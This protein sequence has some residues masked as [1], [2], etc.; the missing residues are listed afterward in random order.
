M[1]HTE[2]KKLVNIIFKKTANIFNGKGKKS[3]PGSK[4]NNN[5]N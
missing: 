3:E 5:N 2:P 4:N 1:Q